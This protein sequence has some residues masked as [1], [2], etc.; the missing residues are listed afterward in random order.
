MKS[1]SK[2]CGSSADGVIKYDKRDK[3]YRQ[4]VWSDGVSVL[5]KGSDSSADGVM[6]MVIGIQGNCNGCGCSRN[7]LIGCG[8]KDK[9]YQQRVWFFWRWGNRV[10]SEG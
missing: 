7:V 9:V 3:G 10:W 2:G 1:T 8:Q 5:R 4:T 6:G